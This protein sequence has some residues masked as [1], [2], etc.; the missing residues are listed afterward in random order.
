MKTWKFFASL[1]RFQPW[2]YAFNC[3]AII[4][5][6][7]AEMIPGLVGQQFFDRLTARPAVDIGLW[8][9]ITLLLFAVM[10]RIAGIVSCQLTNSPFILCNTALLQKNIL[11]RIL[12]LPEHMPSQPLQEKPSVACAMMSMKMPSF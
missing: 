10:G 9:L 6:L 11:A 1:V 5:V 12:Q 7:L 2:N 3:L 8:W 4:I